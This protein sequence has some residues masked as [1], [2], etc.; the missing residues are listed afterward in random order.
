MTAAAATTARLAAAGRDAAL[1][2]AGAGLA[3]G[4]ALGLTAGAAAVADAG[5][6]AYVHVSW[7]CAK[8]YKPVSHVPRVTGRL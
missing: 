1:L 5:H 4:L 6:A 8:S 7:S 2:G 3:A